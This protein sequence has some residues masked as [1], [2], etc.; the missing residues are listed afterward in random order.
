MAKKQA[1]PSQPKPPA[2]PVRPDPVTP[3]TKGAPL[4]TITK[5]RR[6]RGD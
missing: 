6:G 4:P 1:V 2:Q 3:S 5:T